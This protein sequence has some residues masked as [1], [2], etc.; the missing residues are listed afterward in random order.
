M[1]QIDQIYIDGQ[2]VEP[3]GRE[4]FDLHNPSTGEV[5]GRVRLGDEED[6]R[7]ALAAA[8]RALP[9]F[10]QTTKAERI[11]LL[12]RLHETMLKGEDRLTDA[13]V[14]E[15]G[16]PVGRARWMAHYAAEA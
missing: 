9:I 1:R 13:I 11:A 16:A 6:A 8:K 12:R 10:A 5:I 7:R 15:Y 2:F 4:M 14:E 3:H